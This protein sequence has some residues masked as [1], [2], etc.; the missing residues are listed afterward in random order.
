MQ[1]VPLI[2]DIVLI[3]GGHTHVLLIRKWGMK[4]LAG[5]RLTL[6]SRDVLTPY[7]GMLPAY[8]AGH[9]SHAQ[10]HI[11]LA[12]LC[13][14][15]GVQFIQASVTGL[16]LVANRVFLE[17]R[18][19][20]AAVEFDLVSINTG[21]TPDTSS[22]PGAAEFALP[23]KP[24]NRFA[25]KWHALNHRLNAG[26]TKEVSIAVVGAGV[27]GFELLLSLHYALAGR[28]VAAKLHWIVRGNEPLREQP[29]KV[30]SLAL[31]HCRE[32]NIDVH[33]QFD[34]S[35]VEEKSLTA[36]SG[37]V[38]S[39]DEVLWVTAAT[40]PE[41]PSQA[42]LEVTGRNFISV[43]DHLQSTSHPQVFA[44]G[45]VAT[46]TASPSPKA[47]VFAVRQAPV[48]FENLRR[49]VSGQS[50]R[51]YRPQKNFLSLISL[52]EPSAI[53]SRNRI[54][55]KGDWV[56]RW[57]DW[58][59]TQFMR[60]FSEL[61][62]RDMPPQLIADIPEGLREKDKQT[63]NDYMFCGGCGAKVGPEVLAAVLNELKPFT[64][65]SVVASEHGIADD[66]CVIDT[67]SRHLVQSV[68]QIRANIGDAYL[69]GRI[70]ALHALSD[71]YAGGGLPDSALAL[72]TVGF[73]EA[74]IQ[75][76]DLAL[77]MSGAVEELN[78]ARCMLAG[79][80]SSVGPESMLGFVVNGFQRDN[81]VNVANVEAGDVLILTKPLGTGVVMAAHMRAQANGED[82][83]RV[84]DMMLQSNGPAA[85]I[86]SS[87]GALCM[88]D[89]TGFGLLGHT[90][91]LLDRVNA[92]KRK[93]LKVS[94]NLSQVPVFDA[95]VELSK[96]NFKS[97]LFAQNAHF[98]SRLFGAV[99]PEVNDG[100]VRERLLMD[101]QTNG[102]MLAIV[103]GSAANDCLQQLQ[104]TFSSVAVIGTLRDATT[105]ATT[106]AAS[107]DKVSAGVFLEV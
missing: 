85:E 104:Q 90:L 96:R 20:L 59:D 41:W 40:A 25:G 47:G 39:F 74:D 30:R 45:D 50:L 23:V 48:L 102:G 21:S 32:K 43:N 16:D 76:R 87:H 64:S 28:G 55:L 80:H 86:F 103:P 67:G 18:P 92:A 54:V 81:P 66:S 5:V 57:K 63:A 82:V 84:I 15:A 35:K 95:A 22:V 83:A 24:V 11:D 78:A 49:A 31:A 2:K 58:I 14:W 94:L 27:G 26:D 46:Q 33:L 69:F 6:I 34:V 98:R 29:E 42:G 71:V 51:R 56:W 36:S 77:M 13:Q 68:D 52:G 101:P 53:A 93:P 12:R 79:G 10:T 88:T 4:P 89:V 107:A 38:V 9:Y 61:P 37:D 100:L 75:R 3:G 70:A 19:Q 99:P 73:S 97:S 105:L 72:V 7:S 106:S 1:H 65:E 8:V 91:N 44:C 60:K 17:Q 62:E